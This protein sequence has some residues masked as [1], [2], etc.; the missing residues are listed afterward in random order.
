[1]L[2]LWDCLCQVSIVLL[3]EKMALVG[4]SE[5]GL[6]KSGSFLFLSLCVLGI[7]HVFPLPRN[8]P[9]AHTLP[10]ALPARC[11]P[12]HPAHP[13][14]CL[15]GTGGEGEGVSGVGM[16][17]RGRGALGKGKWVSAENP[18][19]RQIPLLRL[20]NTRAP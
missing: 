5:P 11:L 13:Q 18:P 2:I 1:M 19:A 20:K 3:A 10:C 6:Q 7:Q 14:P 12:P 17:L 9:C 4:D 16:A 8:V 15:G